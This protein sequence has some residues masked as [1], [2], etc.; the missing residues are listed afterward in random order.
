M[1][2]HAGLQDTGPPLAPETSRALS[3]VYDGLGSA[4]TYIRKQLKFL[5]AV[6]PSQ[7]DTLIMPM[8]W[9]PERPE[10]PVPNKRQAEK[11]R[12]LLYINCLH[13]LFKSRI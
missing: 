10:T 9:S 3:A 2:S 8:D 5:Q 12:L 6:D 13:V 1:G 7:L 4:A 11:D